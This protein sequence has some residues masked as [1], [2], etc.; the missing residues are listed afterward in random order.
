[1]TDESACAGNVYQSNTGASGSPK[2]VLLQVPNKN[3]SV[4]PDILHAWCLRL[5]QE[6][7]PNDTHNL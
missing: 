1:M 4:K 7:F 3:C 5:Y 2:G 6:S